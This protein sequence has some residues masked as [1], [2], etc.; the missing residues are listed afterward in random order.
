MS[1]FCPACLILAG[2]GHLLI[3]DG[4]GTR[5]DTVSRTRDN[6]EAFVALLLPLRWSL[7]TYCRRMLRD[8]SLVEDV[9]Q[10]AIVQAFARFGD[11]S[12]GTNFRAWIFRFVTLEIFNQN[13]KRMPAPLS[14]VPEQ[15]AQADEAFSEAGMETLLD[16][17]DRLME[18]FEEHVASALSELT[19]PERTVLL[20]RA[21]GEFSYR[22]IQDVLSIPLGSVMGYLSRARLK[23]R[24]SLAR[25]AAPR[26]GHRDLRNRDYELR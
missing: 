25:H 12:Q 21:L 16:D 18:H 2:N 26:G 17:P 23:M 20:L 7:E 10:T 3:A 11:Y 15:P 24:R 22:E 14:D 19:G 13:R 4:L 5:S 9:L 8:P 6:A 1:L